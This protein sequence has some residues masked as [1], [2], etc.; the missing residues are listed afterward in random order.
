VTVIAVVQTTLY[1]SV[2]RTSTP[3]AAAFS[4][5]GRRGLHLIIDVTAA[6]STPSVVPTID[7]KDDLSGKW[8]NLLTGVAITATGTTVLKI[9]P[10]IGQATNAAASDIIPANLRLVMTHGNANSATY[11]AA[12]HLVP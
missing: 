10:G 5:Q 2:A 6:T 11:T 1:D 3:T 8:Y 12:V 4:S 7:G 9:Y